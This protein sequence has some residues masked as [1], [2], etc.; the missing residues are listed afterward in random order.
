[1]AWKQGGQTQVFPDITAGDNS[2]QPGW[3]WIPTWLE[4]Q[5]TGQQVSVR[6]QP[7]IY[8]YS[9]CVFDD[10]QSHFSHTPWF[11]ALYGNRQVDS[12]NQ[13]VGGYL[14]KFSLLANVRR[15]IVYCS[16]Y[17]FLE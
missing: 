8:R 11:I 14:R 10:I 12:R 3:C 15:F 13:E 7:R 2:I 17:L 4:F 16:K 6:T 9:L 1:M 5:N